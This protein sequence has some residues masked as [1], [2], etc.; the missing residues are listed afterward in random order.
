MKIGFWNVGTKNDLSDMLVSWT[1]ERQLDIICLAEVSDNVKLSFLKKINKS[2]TTKS[3]KQVK[4]AK[5]KIT[6]ISSY[7]ASV[8]KDKSH[9]YSSG[10]WTAHKIQI[11]GLITFNLLAV[12]F[13]SKVNWSEA[14]LSLECVNFSRDIELIESITKC[15]NTVLIG[16]FNMNPFENGLV[17]ANGINAIPDL[18]YASK[19]KKGRRIDGINYNYFYNPMWNFF[20]DFNKPY[21]THYCR[22]SG[23]ISHEWH[24]YDQLIL[25]PSMKQYFDK[26]FVE[27]TTNISGSSLITNLKRPDNKNYSDHLPIIFNLKI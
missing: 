14:S 12:H 16:D 17:A 9:K 10:R 26:P 19:R 3:F 5:S 21:G 13:H 20:G 18:E 8:F 24:I 4:C 1:N 25:R 2:G 6:I 27:I 7:S 11:P 23:H 22:P 15:K